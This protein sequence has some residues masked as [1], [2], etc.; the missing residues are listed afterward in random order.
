MPYTG[1][2]YCC[3]QAQQPRQIPSTWDALLCA[4]VIAQPR[5][6]LR[7][8]PHTPMQAGEKV[9]SSV[10]QLR[11]VSEGWCQHSR[12][13]VSPTCA[14]KLSQ[15]WAHQCAVVHAAGDPRQRGEEDGQNAD[16]NPPLQAWDAMKHYCS[17]QE[18]CGFMFE[19]CECVADQP[20]SEETYAVIVSSGHDAGLHECSPQS[21]NYRRSPRP[22]VCQACGRMRW[23]ALP[24]GSPRCFRR[25]AEGRA[26]PYTKRHDFNGCPGD[27]S[28]PCRCNTL[29]TV[30]TAQ[31][32]PKTGRGGQRQRECKPQIGLAAPDRQPWHW[33]SMRHRAAPRDEACEPTPV[34]THNC[35][36]P[37]VCGSRIGPRWHMRKA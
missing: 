6:L 27:M 15:G 11:W 24:P 19:T 9:A 4:H 10:K 8:D 5:E 20:A 18:H 30:H 13:R 28:A 23:Q 34:V 37:S 7:D 29:R 3:V 31:G 17:R 36:A 16:R 21:S 26:A 35:T 1:I 14:A 33:Q 25:V 2:W 12:R 22:L 32:N